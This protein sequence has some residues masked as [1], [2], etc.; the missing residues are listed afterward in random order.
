MGR[1]LCEANVQYSVGGGPTI[2]KKLQRTLNRPIPIQPRRQHAHAEVEHRQGQQDADA[3]TDAPDGGEVIFARGGED[4]EE[5]GDGEGAA[6]LE[7]G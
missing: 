5:D 6:E 1:D 4:D 3:E 2:V 7:G